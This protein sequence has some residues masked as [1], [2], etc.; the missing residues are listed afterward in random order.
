MEFIKLIFNWHLISYT[1]GVALI[2]FCLYSTFF[3]YSLYWHRV[4]SH[5]QAILHPWFADF[6]RFW[7]W[8]NTTIWYQGHLVRFT[9]EHRL[10]HAVSD[11][12]NDP[13]SPKNFRLREF[14]TY[15]NNPGNARYVSAK[16]IIQ[17][18]DASM[19]PNDKFSLFYK[20]HQFNGIWIFRVIWF[21]LLGP[22]GFVIA[23]LNPYIWQYG[24]TF[25][26]DWMWHTIGYK[27]PHVR[28]EARN[29]SPW[30]TLDGL[31]SNH[32][33]NQNNPNNAYRWFELDLFYWQLRLLEIVGLLK[34]NK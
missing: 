33:V 17:F 24:G 26:G 32:H 15:G 4:A 14:F 21:I 30:P 29:I 27:H 20:R 8:I 11:E 34:F 25:F 13:L 1:W 5:K 7:L 6:C 12:P 10:H 2:F 18:G 16:Q 3:I 28:G 9:A 23:Y 22:I 31:H 19:E